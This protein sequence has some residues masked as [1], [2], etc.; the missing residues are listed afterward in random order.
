MLKPAGHFS[1][2]F[3]ALKILKPHTGTVDANPLISPFLFLI[4]DT[5]RKTHSRVMT[6]QMTH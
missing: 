4:G 6:I 3:F 2:N 5:L 1:K